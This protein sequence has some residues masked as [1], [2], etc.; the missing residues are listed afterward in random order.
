MST[1]HT[2]NGLS[3]S[4]R[5]P[6]LSLIARHGGSASIYQGPSL[7]PSYLGTLFSSSQRF[8]LK[9]PRKWL[10]HVATPELEKALKV[11]T[12]LACRGLKRL[13]CRIVVAETW[14]CR[15]CGM[16]SIPRR[17]RGRGV[18]IDLVAVPSAF[19]AE[20]ALECEWSSLTSEKGLVEKRDH[21]DDAAQVAF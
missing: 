3:L 21:E 10:A 1:G 16:R 11:G 7:Q 12:S 2:R 5:S 14:G 15:G 19:R 17:H 4:T 6:A 9:S 18:L 8:P 13:H 20:S